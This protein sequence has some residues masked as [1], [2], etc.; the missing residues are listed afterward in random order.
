MDK[1]RVRVRDSVRVKLK[2]R[3]RV[4]VKIRD[5]LWGELGNIVPG[6]HRTWGT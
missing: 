6:E 5:S 2:I 1:V 3:V 4:R